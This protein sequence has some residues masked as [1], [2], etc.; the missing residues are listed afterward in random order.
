M[1]TTFRPTIFTFIVDDFGVKYNDIK[2]EMHL[3]KALKEHYNVK[4]DWSGSR[5]EEIKLD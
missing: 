1:E 4:V 3:I 5:H 2:N